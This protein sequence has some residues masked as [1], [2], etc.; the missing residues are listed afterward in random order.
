[1]GCKRFYQNACKIQIKATIIL[2]INNV[3]YISFLE[4]YHP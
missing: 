3:F 4:T 2:W 1:L